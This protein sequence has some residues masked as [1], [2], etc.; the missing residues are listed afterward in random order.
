MLP[1]A[2][3]DLLSHRLSASNSIA[4]LPIQLSGRVRH[5]Q[6]LAAHHPR[7]TLDSDAI[8]MLQGSRGARS[9]HTF[10]VSL[11]NA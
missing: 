5:V 9:V 3:L 4:I 10:P 1:S 2:L 8:P 6:Q 11:S 7:V